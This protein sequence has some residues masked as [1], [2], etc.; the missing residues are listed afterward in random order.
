[1]SCRP[2]LDRSCKGED[3]VPLCLERVERR[4]ERQLRRTDAAF[5]SVVRSLPELPRPPLPVDWLVAEMVERYAVVEEST[6]QPGQRI[7]EIGSGGQALATIPLACRI[8]S[9]GRVTAVERER[10]DRFRELVLA[11]GLGPRIDP[12]R[13]DAR[14]LPFSANTFRLATCIHGLRSLG[15]DDTCLRVFRE[16]LRVADRLFVAESLPVGRTEAQLAHLTMYE[17]REEMF[18]ATTG[19]RDDVHYRSLDELCALV[20]RA[21]GVVDFHRA[22]ELDLPHALSYFPRSMLGAVPDPSLRD[23]LEERWDRAFERLQRVGE[24]HPPVGMVLARTR[25]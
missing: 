1:M 21:G 3:V 23:R 15:D 7:V 20:E 24:D 22:L 8:G 6:V 5:Q 9:N 16:M 2:K 12:V 10:W 17:L 14:R 13:A 19:R 4:T 18:L 11:S 25:T